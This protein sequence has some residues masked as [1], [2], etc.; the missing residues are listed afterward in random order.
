MDVSAEQA[1][2]LLRLT[3]LWPEW[4]V[5]VIEG[6]WSA[7]RKDDPSVTLVAESPLE[8]GEMLRAVG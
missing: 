4:W 7:T 8:L 5:M 1:T 3:S 6:T 2:C